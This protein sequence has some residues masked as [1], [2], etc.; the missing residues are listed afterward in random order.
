M[1][2]AVLPIT[3]PAG[4]E[5]TPAD[6]TDMAVPALIVPV[7]LNVPWL[8]VVGPVYVWLLPKVV[9]PAPLWVRDKVPPFLVTTFALIFQFP[10]PPKRNVRLA[11]PLELKNTLAPIVA[12]FVELLIQLDPPSVTLVV[13]VRLALPSVNCAG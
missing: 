12:A 13:V 8:T 5:K 10:A 2:E 6:A 1:I 3:P 11:A 4:S 9:M 7:R